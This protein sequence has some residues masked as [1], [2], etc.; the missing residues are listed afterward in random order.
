MSEEPKGVDRPTPPPPRARTGE[1]LSEEELRR[2]VPSLAVERLRSR[3]PDAV[4]EVSY[5]AGNP[6]VVV[7]RERLLEVMALL[8]DDPA[9][10]MAY[11]AD[12]CGVDFPDRPQRFEVVYQPRSLRRGHALTIK[13]RLADGEEAPSVTGVWPSANW[14]EREA[15][16][17]LGIRFAG[18]PN[19]KRILLTD[20]WVGHPLRKEY[21][22]EGRPEDHMLLRDPGFRPPDISTGILPFKP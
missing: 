18:H 4:L 16:D 15:Y 12:L 10:D 11:L 21:P 1:G 5:Y 19:L 6:I 3:F 13:I 8:K 22:T 14:F 9:L 20:T 2:E 17:L 7:A